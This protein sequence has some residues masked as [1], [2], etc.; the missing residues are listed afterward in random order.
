MKGPALSPV[1]A[2]IETT[3][4]VY[5]SRMFSGR[6]CLPVEPYVGIQQVTSRIC[7]VLLDVH[8]AL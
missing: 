3:W 8:I 7:V 1:R 2:Y 4:G 5:I 6:A